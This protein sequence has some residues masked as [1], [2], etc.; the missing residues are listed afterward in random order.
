MLLGPLHLF[1]I[2]GWGALMCCMGVL[3]WSKGIGNVFA[4]TLMLFSVS[5]P[6]K[7]CTL[8]LAGQN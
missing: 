6:T 8:Q 2:R 3:A 7:E 5:Q 4:K 1:C